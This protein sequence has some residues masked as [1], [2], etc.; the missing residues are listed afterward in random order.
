MKTSTLLTV[1]FCAVFALCPSAWAEGNYNKKR[2]DAGASF[3]K[4]ID[5]LPLMPGLT[6]AQDDDVLF[7]TRTG[8]IAQTIATGAIDVDEVYQFYH[9]A[10]PQLGWKAVDARSFE[11]DNER[12]RLD[13]SGVTPDANTV[14]KFSVQ[15]IQAGK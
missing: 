3:A 1:A 4:V 2:D 10:L 11:R 15:P 13:V 9:K 6:I 5:D 14:V 8:R 7:I 12:L